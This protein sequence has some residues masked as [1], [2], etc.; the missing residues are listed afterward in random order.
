MVSFHAIE[1]LVSGIGDDVQTAQQQL[2]ELLKDFP[3][4]DVSTGEGLELLRATSA[5]PQD[6]PK[7]APEDLV[8]A[9]PAGELRLH[10]FNPVGRPRAVILRLHG[11][12]WAAGA[13]EDD[14]AVND[15]LARV[16]EIAVVSPEYRLVPEATLADQI[17]DCMAAARWT[18]EHAEERFGT[19]RVLLAGTSAGAYLAA[20]VLLALR[21]AGGIGFDL[22]RGVHLD[23]GAYD[24][25]GT[26]SERESTRASLVL[27]RDLIDG[28][29]E[30]ALPGVDPET[31]RQPSISPLYANLTGLP[32][33]LFT[34]GALDPLR[35]D[36]AFMSARWRLAGNPADLDVWPEAAHAFS[37][38]AGPLASVALERATSWIN[39]IINAESAS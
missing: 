34:V 22:I 17:D 31:R 6:P 19:S 4:P 24:L 11:G 26:P 3:Q 1:P 21:D 15:R 14:E 20:M 33:A 35:D 30:L 13:P 8:I 23:C 7:Q 37:N 36:A 5:P 39:S 27:S 29:M 18:L 12:G 2:N 32:P 28:L 10:T 38:M 16:C 9:G 25:S